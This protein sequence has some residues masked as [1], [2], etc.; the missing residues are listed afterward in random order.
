MKIK[1]TSNSLMLSSKDSVFLGFSEGETKIQLSQLKDDAAEYLAE[2]FRAFNFTGKSEQSILVR[3]PGRLNVVAA[4]LG[5]KE[6][7][8]INTF[9]N[10]VAAAVK[11]ADKSGIREI[12]FSPLVSEL[13]STADVSR[14]IAESAVMAQYRFETYKT[15]KSDVSVETLVISD[16]EENEKKSIEKAVQE[17]LVLAELNVR[18]RELI[19]TSPG[20]ATPEYMAEQARG[21]AKENGLGIRIIGKKEM[22]ELGMNGILAVGSGS[23]NEPKLVIMEYQSPGADKMIALVGKGV[24]FDSG[25]LDIKPAPYMEDMKMDKAGAITV[26]LTMEA[27]ARLKP[28]LNVVALMPFVENLVSDRSYK[29]GDIITTMSGKTIE[30]LNTDAEGRVILSDALHYAATQYEPEAMVDVA[31]L[32]GA[33]ITALGNNVAGVMGNDKSLISRLIV[34]GT[35]TYERLWELPLFEDYS[36]LMESDHAD[37][38]NVVSNMP[39]NPAGTITG[40]V[41]LSHFVGGTPWAHLDIAGTAWSDKDRNYLSKGATGFGVRLLSQFLLDYE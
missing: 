14:A 22:H 33:V 27:V 21:I 38:K 20:I 26:M 32:T 36:E 23:H 17:G 12:S 3:L 1:V 19:N 35:K 11:L 31:T 2:S 34:A 37:V 24:C 30:I 16:I 18:A 13:F 10:A 5:E 15:E 29:P 28:R 25:G 40:A 7:F 6:K 4:G 8:S 9:R 41:F 39:G